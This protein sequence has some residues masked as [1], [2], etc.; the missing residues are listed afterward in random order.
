[1]TTNYGARPGLTVEPRTMSAEYE[2]QMRDVAD[3]TYEGSLSARGVSDLLAELDA[4]RA[5]HAVTLAAC[6]AAM[7]QLEPIVAGLSTEANVRNHGPLSACRAAIA[8]ARGAQ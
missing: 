5:S 3:D 6:E 2:R 8:K 7:R 4:E 1:M